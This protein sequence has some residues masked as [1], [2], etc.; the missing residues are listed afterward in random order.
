MD[1]EKCGRRRRGR[2][3]RLL[4]EHARAR[5]RLASLACAAHRLISLARELARVYPIDICRILRLCLWLSS[6]LSPSG[7][8]SFWPFVLLFFGPSV[9]LSFC[10]SDLRSLGLFVLLS[11]NLLGPFHT[12]IVGCR[13]S[14]LKDIV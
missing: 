10:L 3:R 11:L 2:A 13:L 7:L 14:I 5:E 8:L 12:H 4:R 9:L 6:Y 1:W